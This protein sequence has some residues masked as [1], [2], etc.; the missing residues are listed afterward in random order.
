MASSSG[1]YR[2]VVEVRRAGAGAKSPV[3][4]AY[5]QSQRWRRA[6]RR[7]ALSTTTLD[8]CPGSTY[9]QHLARALSHPPPPPRSPRKM[10][11]KKRDRLVQCWCFNYC[12]KHG[13]RARIVTARTLA[14]NIAEDQAD[15]A[16][17]KARC[18]PVIEALSLAA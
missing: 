7:K 10:P 9:Q 13:D 5:P 3:A 4:P 16:D 11:K 6:H 15:I 17:A 18:R 12:A 2:V 14:K 8:A 1:H